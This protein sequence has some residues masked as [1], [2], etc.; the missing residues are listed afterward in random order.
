VDGVF[1]I[2]PP[3]KKDGVIPRVL[4]TKNLKEKHINE[5]V[6]D[7]AVFNKNTVSFTLKLQ[8]MIKG[9][10]LGAQLWFTLF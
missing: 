10:V 3:C 4:L 6:E 1:S 5:T 2:I 8:L 9:L 7:V